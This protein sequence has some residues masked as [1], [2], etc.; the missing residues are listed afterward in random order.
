MK[1]GVYP[2]GT[3]SDGTIACREGVKSW[4]MLVLGS[5]V[6]KCNINLKFC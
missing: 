5:E 2:K 6:L 1:L 4:I 3:D